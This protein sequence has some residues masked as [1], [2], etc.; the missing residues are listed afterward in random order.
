MLRSTP[1]RKRPP[2]IPSPR[3]ATPVRSPAARPRQPTSP[4]RSPAPEKTRSRTPNPL[5][6]PATA[7]MA[8]RPALN[9][10]DHY[11]YIIGYPD[12]DVHPQGNI[13]RAEV[14]TIFFRLLRD[15]V[16]TQ[17]WSQ[18]NDYSDVRGQQVVQQRDLHALQHGH[19]LRLS[20]RHLPPRRADH[21]C[22]ADQDRRRA[23][24]PI[25]ASRRPM[26]A[27]SPMFMAPNGT[28]AT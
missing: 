13:T 9:R 12:G 28:S 2:A 15:P 24:S 14:A 6:N 25:R 5:L 16:R 7:A 17:Y 23:S 4:T 20:G 27:A 18:T 10:R 21:P 8:A 19:H 1:F 11:A 26:T 22:R 3:P